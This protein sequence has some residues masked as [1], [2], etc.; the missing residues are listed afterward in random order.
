MNI[1]YKKLHTLSLHASITVSERLTVTR[2]PGG[3]IYYFKDLDFTTEGFNVANS[4][5]VPFT[6]F[7][8]NGKGVF[9]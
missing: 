2:V 1:E 6:D 9:G 3:L 4:V 8:S 5:F 7:E